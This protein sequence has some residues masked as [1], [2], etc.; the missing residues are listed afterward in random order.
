MTDSL[1][2]L[3]WPAFKTKLSPYNQLL[4]K[5]MQRLGATVEEFSVG[6]VMTKQY[7]I[8]H[9][10]WPEYCVNDRGLLAAL[11]WSCALFGA[12]CWVRVRGGST[13]WTVHN[14]GSHLQQHPTIERYFWKTFTALLNAYISLTEKG[15]EQARQRY[16]SLRTIPG[17]VIPH[18]NLR[19]AYPGIDISREQART[20]LGIEPSARVLTFFGSIDSYKGVTELVEKFPAVPDDRAVLLV[21]GKCCL[22]PH[23]RKRIEDIAAGD[24]RVVLHLDYVPYTD[25]ACYIRAADLLVLPF[26]EILNSGSAILALSL[27]RPVLVPAKDSMRELEEFAGPDWVRLYSGELTSEVLQRELDNA[28]GSATLRARCRALEAGWKGLDWRHLAQL[29]LDA[30]HS[31]RGTPRRQQVSNCQQVGEG[32]QASSNPHACGPTVVC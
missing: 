1:R 30:Y 20:R 14:L 19:D 13:V 24:R 27:D 3:A 8:V 4:Y 15:G 31:V 17:F 32:Q 12:M 22:R 6:R 25:V 18:G 9:F 21:A 7:H 23:E 16:P 28:V 5:S 29:T 11:F 26:R 10:H 2:I